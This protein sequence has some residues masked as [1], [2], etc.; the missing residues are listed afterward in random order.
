MK[1]LSIGILLTFLIISCSGGK[2]RKKWNR[3]RHWAP[4]HHTKAHSSGE[5]HVLHK[6]SFKKDGSYGSTKNVVVGRMA[7]FAVGGR[8]RV[9]IADEGNTR[10]D[11]FSPDGRYLKSL[12]RQGNG[13]GEFA[14]VSPRTVIRTRSGRLYVPDYKN[15]SDYFPDR[16]QVFSLDSLAFIRT[17]QLLAPN[18]SH[19]SKLDAY[20]PDHVYPRSDGRFLVGYR[21]QPNKYLDSTSYIRYVIQNSSGAIVKGPILQ[22]K[23]RT[24][25]KY[26]RQD[27]KIPITD[28][29]W[30]PFFGK[31]I[32]VRSMRGRLYAVHNTQQFKIEV[33]TPNGKH[34]RSFRH[35]FHKVPLSRHALINRYKKKFSRNGV[36]IP[37]KMIRHAH[38]LPKT[39]PALH[40]MLMDD[41]NRLGVSTIVKS[42]KIYRWWVMNN[43]GTVLAKFNW[44]RSK[45]I[46]KVKHG[47]IY[48]LEKNNKGV[49]QV[50]RYKIQMQ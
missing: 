43:K 3:Q 6:I 24:Y 47:Y 5:H 25:L 34:L 35:S 9:F 20:Y 23:D 18:K 27:L 14:T 21:K 50:V 10:V 8:G 44:P 36:N 26:V 42:R 31:S 15:A 37:V 22:Q 38:T 49:P 41:Q 39:W 30:F 7:S 28:A 29:F 32:L 11:V 17:V 45:P 46:K 16:L 48:T 4:G 33:Y 19:Y 40:S 12:G 2:N 1:I 13:P